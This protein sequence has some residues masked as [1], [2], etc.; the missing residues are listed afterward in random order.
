MYKFLCISERVF[1]D[2]GAY[3]LLLVSVFYTDGD[4]GSAGVY[5]PCA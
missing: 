5:L 4:S 2:G 1:D 3:P